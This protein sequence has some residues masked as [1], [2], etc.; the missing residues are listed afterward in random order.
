MTT[1]VEDEIH[2]PREI[3]ILINTDKLIKFQYEDKDGL[4]VICGFSTYGSIYEEVKKRYDLSTGKR[5]S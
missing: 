4:V 3:E 2:W 1:K 5:I